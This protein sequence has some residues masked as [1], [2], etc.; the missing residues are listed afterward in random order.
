MD[1]QGL[2][3]AKRSDRL[4]SNAEVTLTIQRALSLSNRD[5]SGKVAAF[6]ASNRCAPSIRI[7]TQ[8]GMR[9][10]RCNYSAPDRENAKSSARTW[11]ATTSIGPAELSLSIGIRSILLRSVI[12]T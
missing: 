3:Q 8:Y 4:I 5:Y 7:Q 1:I 2:G 9:G 11:S 12:E 6:G 10:M